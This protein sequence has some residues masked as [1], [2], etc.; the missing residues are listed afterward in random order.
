MQEEIFGPI[1]PVLTYNRFMDVMAEIQS[2]PTPLAF[3]LFTRDSSRK[4]FYKKFSLL[5]EGALM[6]RS[7]SWQL[8]TCLLAGWDNLVWA[9]IM[10]IM[11][12]KISRIQNQ[13]S[14]N[15]R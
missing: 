7:S 15:A 5:A 2:R 4:N 6:I 11:A 12:L 1:L 10:V 9:N 8:K 3:Y 14:I 13:S